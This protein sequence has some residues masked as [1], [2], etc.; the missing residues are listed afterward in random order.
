LLEADEPVALATELF[1]HW[2]Q[3]SAHLDRNGVGA[4][5]GD[6]TIEARLPSAHNP[7]EPTATSRPD[8][9]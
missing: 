2:R 5:A 9:A 3:G 6:F 7:A 1:E 8:D 4:V